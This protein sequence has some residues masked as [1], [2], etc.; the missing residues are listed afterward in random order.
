MNMDK[1]TFDALTNKLRRH[2]C[3]KLVQVDHDGCSPGHQIPHGLNKPGCEC[4]AEAPPDGPWH[5]N[6]AIA[7]APR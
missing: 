7:S 2:G 5:M 6:S 4:D 1:V 3:A